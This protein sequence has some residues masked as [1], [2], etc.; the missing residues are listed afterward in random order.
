MK[1]II[2][3]NKKRI[4]SLYL[5][6]RK[7]ISALFYTIGINVSNLNCMS[8][9]YKNNGRTRPIKLQLPSESM[10]LSAIRKA[11]TLKQDDIWKTTFLTQISKL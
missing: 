5:V 7:V 1:A 10:V 11:K 3:E 8:V 6:W 2:I 4:A 9:W